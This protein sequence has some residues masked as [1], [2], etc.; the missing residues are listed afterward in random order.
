MS[1]TTKT[2]RAHAEMAARFM[3]DS[4]LKCWSW[5]SSAKLWVENKRPNWHENMAYHVGHEKPTAPP[6]R[7]ITMAGV[8]FDAPETEAPEAGA[9]YWLVRL[10]T[11]SVCPKRWNDYPDDHWGLFNGLIH[12]DEEN[13]ILH[14]QALREWNRQLCGMEDAA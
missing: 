2:P 1:E 3:A 13:A 4:S 11:P 7:R 8:T 10:G 9:K 14:F 6:K 5:M 12:L